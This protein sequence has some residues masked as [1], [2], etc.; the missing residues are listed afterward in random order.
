[1]RIFAPARAPELPASAWLPF[2]ARKTCGER[3]L[4]MGAHRNMKA[5]G[6]IEIQEFDARANCDDG[7]LAPDSPLLRFFDTAAVAVKKFGM[8]F[9]A[10]EALQEPLERAGFVNVQCV[11]L[12]VPIGTWAKVSGPS[13]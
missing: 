6:W 7:T 4:M 3:A 10:G 11:T 13:S 12:K 9:R 2:D 1:V 8:N 5:G